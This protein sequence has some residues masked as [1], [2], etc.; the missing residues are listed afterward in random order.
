MNQP[1]PM[2]QKGDLI[3]LHSMDEDAR[4]H[5]TGYRFIVSDAQPGDTPGSGTLHPT[6]DTRHARQLDFTRPSA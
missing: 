1:E 5:D 4:E 2:P 6:Q 3:R